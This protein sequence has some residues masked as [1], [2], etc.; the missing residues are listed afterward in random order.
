MKES[1]FEEYALMQ[2]FPIDRYI[3]PR[4]DFSRK[5]KILVNDDQPIINHYIKLVHKNFI[6]K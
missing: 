2:P 6:L 3:D 1:N 4:L 5:S